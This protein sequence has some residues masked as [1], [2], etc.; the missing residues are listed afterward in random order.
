TKEVTSGR[1]FLL[2]YVEC[3]YSL[4]CRMHLWN[5]LRL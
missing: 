1:R 3:L 5:A 4:S 2:L